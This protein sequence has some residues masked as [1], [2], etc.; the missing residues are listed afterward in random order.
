MKFP[1]ITALVGLAA[2]AAAALAVRDA[3]SDAADHPGQAREKGP[4]SI[5]WERAAAADEPSPPPVG[6]SMPSGIKVTY[7]NDKGY[8]NPCQ[9]DSTATGTCSESMVA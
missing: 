6:A 2:T 1:L 3:E 5:G 7:C 9:S 4:G 8:N